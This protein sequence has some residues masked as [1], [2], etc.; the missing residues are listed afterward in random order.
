MTSPRLL[1]VAPSTSY[2]VGA[3]LNAARKLGVSAVVASDGRHSLISSFNQGIHI[4]P[5]DTEGTIG[6]LLAEARAR[7]CAGVIGTDDGTVEIASRLARHLGL[8]GND[9]DAAIVTRRKDKARERLESAG[10]TVPEHAVMDIAGIIAGKLPE[11]PFPLVLKPL[12]MSGSR[13]VIRSDD[14]E[15]FRSAARRIGQI[16]KEQADDFE[17]QTVLV[18]RYLPGIEVA[19][20][21]MLY[22]GQ[23]TVLALFDKPEPLEGPFFEETYYI[24]PSR[25]PARVQERI[26]ATVGAACAALGLHHG[27]IHAEL[28][29][30]GER[31]GILEVASRTIGGQCARLLSYGTDAGL[32]ELVV[33][34]ALGRPLAVD[35]PKGASGVLMIPIPRAGVL[36]RVEG[37]LEA[38]KVP[39]IVDVE[40]TRR[41][42]YEL[43]PLP[44]GSS[45]LGFVFARTDTP[46][47]AEV[48][49]RQAHTR[50]SVVVA[51]AWRIRQAV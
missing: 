23:L 9:P 41:E 5:A 50:L 35:T 14:P 29:I 3:Y 28:R 46:G 30:D 15:T 33:A 43:V 17:R 25:L 18:E 45:Y 38:Q 47:Q 2:R 13:G 34:N 37:V 20:E 51:P 6:A 19:L 31:T 26:A 8:P 36:R 12:A 49:L 21:G 27:P 44:E 32:E 7:N 24:T 1:L 42:G 22:E 40:I 39:G 48:A 4:D 16:I 11:I 10:V